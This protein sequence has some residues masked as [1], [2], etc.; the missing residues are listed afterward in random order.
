M[1]SRN[2]F[3]SSTSRIVE[4][5]HANP[6]H[7]DHT[8]ADQGHQEDHTLVDQD[9]QEDQEPPLLQLSTSLQQPSQLED[10]LP[11]DLIHADHT[12][13]DQGH[14]EDHTLVDQGQLE[15]QMPSTLVDQSHI[16]QGQPRDLQRSQPRDLQRSHPEDYL[17]N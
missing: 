12:L 9:L 1:V 4:G 11:A 7:A 14:Q 6:I 15:D 8:H 16:D 5:T 17:L 10:Q 2:A 13:V 3:N